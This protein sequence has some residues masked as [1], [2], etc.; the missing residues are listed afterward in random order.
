[1]LGGWSRGH[2][3]HCPSCS[4]SCCPFDS[5]LSHMHTHTHTGTQ[6]YVHTHAPTRLPDVRQSS[7]DLGWDG[8]EQAEGRRLA[9]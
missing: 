7:A 9:L 5:L 6:V 8:G 1:M 3:W 2:Q 4:L